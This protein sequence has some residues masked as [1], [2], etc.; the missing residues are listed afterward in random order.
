M[1]RCLKISSS[2]LVTVF[3]CNACQKHGGIPPIPSTLTVSPAIDTI[4]GVITITG[5]GFST[6]I[7][8]DTVRFNDTTLGQV[9]TASTTQLTVVVPY[10]TA[11][12]RII[13]KTDS[14]Q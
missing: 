14:A 13:V 12:D 3:V 4:G 9:L 10:Y 5:S 11:K 2:I 6:N 7:N 8:E 1:N